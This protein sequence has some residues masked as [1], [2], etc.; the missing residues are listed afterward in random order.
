MIFLQP[1]LSVSSLY[2]TSSSLWSPDALLL[3]DLNSLRSPNCQQR[4]GIGV[5]HLIEHVRCGGQG[6]SSWFLMVFS[7]FVWCSARKCSYCWW[8]RDKALCGFILRR[9]SLTDSY[10][11]WLVINH[12]LSAKAIFESCALFALKILVLIILELV[13]VNI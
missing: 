5:L 1:C 7:A 10:Q 12:T 9:H 6:V 13:D 4:P 2:S 8:I 11:W 3:Y